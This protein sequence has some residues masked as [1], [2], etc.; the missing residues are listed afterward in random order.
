MKGNIDQIIS[1]KGIQN[2]KSNGVPNVIDVEEVIEVT[3][4]DFLPQA[5]A[6]SKKFS[7]IRSETLSEMYKKFPLSC[8]K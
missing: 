4:C 2:K 6:I 7:L 8:W 5:Q 3:A 1:K